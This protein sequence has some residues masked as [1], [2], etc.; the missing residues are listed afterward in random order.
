M[1][2][3]IIIVTYKTKKKGEPGKHQRETKD[4]MITSEIHSYFFIESVCNFYVSVTF[5]YFKY[6]GARSGL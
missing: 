6:K 5:K 1:R 4:A 3:T 2:S